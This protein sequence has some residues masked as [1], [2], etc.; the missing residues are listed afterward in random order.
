LL[1]ELQRTGYTDFADEILKTEIEHYRELIAWQLQLRA[2]LTQKLYEYGDKNNLSTL[3]E[4]LTTEYTELKK[5]SLFQTNFETAIE[6]LRDIDDKARDDVAKGELLLHWIDREAIDEKQGISSEILTL[7]PEPITWKVAIEKID[8]GTKEEMKKSYERSINCIRALAV[9]SEKLYNEKDLKTMTQL[10]SKLVNNKNI[11]YT[12]A[13]V[14]YKG[15][16]FITGLYGYYG[17]NH[18]KLEAFPVLWLRDK[19]A[20]NSKSKASYIRT[21]IPHQD[22]SAIKNTYGDGADFP[23]LDAQTK[24]DLRRHD[25]IANDFWGHQA[26]RKNG[27][28][29]VGDIVLPWVEVQNATP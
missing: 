4:L 5:D 17:E 28:K 29:K 22:F 15:L 25:I 12:P 23:E 19:Y 18:Y 6:V 24:L 8:E 16:D 3:E 13:G 10:H 7:S 26:R 11:S 14:Y 9:I 21:D 1:S 2:Y 27:D 20:N